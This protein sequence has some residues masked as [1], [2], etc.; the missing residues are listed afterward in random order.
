[1][2]INNDEM[3][4]IPYYK[5]VGEGVIDRIVVFVVIPE[6]AVVAAMTTS[7]AALLL[8]SAVVFFI[9]I[10]VVAV[11]LVDDDDLSFRLIISY[12]VAAS[13]LESKTPIYLDRPSK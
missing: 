8:A 9:V 7:S 13:N 12:A 4:P 5:G 2:L 10:V 11:V 3:S 1:M 6:I